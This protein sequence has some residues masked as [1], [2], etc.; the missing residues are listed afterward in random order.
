MR[1]MWLQDPST[2]KVWNLL[3][4]NPYDIENGCP[5]ISIKGMGYEQDITQKQVEVDYF[6]SE[7]SSKNKAVSGVLYFYGTEHVKKFCAFIGDFRKQFKLFY[8]PNGEYK[9]YDPISPIFYKYVTISAIDKTELNQY[10]WYECSTTFTTQSDLWKRDI[11]YSIEG[12]PSVGDPLVYP[13]HYDDSEYIFGGRAIYSIEVNNE[14]R[15]TGCIV[16]I[17][18]NGETPLTEV[19]WFIENTYKDA[20]GNDQTTIQRSKWFTQ[21]DKL[22]LYEGY[23]LI[24]N[25][26]PTTQEAKVVFTDGTSQ[27]VVSLQEP[28]WDYINFVTVKNG[29]NRIVFYVDNPDVKIDF[30]YSEQKELI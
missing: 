3:P 21:E 2:N 19:E 10:G 18:N 11:S 16:S 14:G 20:F 30:S 13:Y 26:N 15:E 4:E 17:T 24:V 29:V 5:F 23:T 6:I 7:I 9:P 28:S 8:S 25:S 1:Q 27:S 12:V 22:T